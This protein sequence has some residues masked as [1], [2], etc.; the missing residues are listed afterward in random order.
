MGAPKHG[1]PSGPRHAAAPARRASRLGLRIAV[2]AVALAAVAVLSVG[3][4]LAVSQHGAAVREGSDAR[5]DVSDAA[6]SDASL[7]AEGEGTA[8]ASSEDAVAFPLTEAS[9]DALASFVSEL[10]GTDRTALAERAADGSVAS[11][12]WSAYPAVSAAVEAFSQRGFD[13]SF[14]L[15]DCSTGRALCYDPDRTYYCASAI[16]APLAAYVVQLA[17]EGGASLDDIVEEGEIIGGS[18]VMAT[19]GVSS[20]A[21][22]EV[23]ENA[24]VAS[25]NTAYRLLWRLFGGEGFELWAAGFGAG[26]AWDAAEYPSLSARD[27]VALWVGTAC[28]AGSGS[29]EAAWFDGL[30]VGTDHSF[31][32]EALDVEATVRS[33]P[34]YD[35]N[36]WYSDGYDMGALH[37][38]GFVEDES[39]AY[40]IAIMSNADCDTDVQTEN[41]ALFEDL[42]RALDGARAAWLAE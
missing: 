23:V 22:R 29:A 33:K 30:L 11:A 6:L 7:S 16:K 39:G 10:P 27:L 42:A 9:A 3:A 15:V 2:I 13:V 1:A 28:F 4:A 24:V 37:D 19:D 17:V 34:G 14:V 31:L 35:S 41:I 32:R 36:L 38:A 5:F 25:D 20:Y 12:D 26:S 8:S 40:L 21:L 18:G